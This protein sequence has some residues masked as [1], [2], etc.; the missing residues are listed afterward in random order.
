MSFVDGLHPTERC[1]G[2]YGDALRAFVRSYWQSELARCDGSVTRAARENGVHRSRLHVILNK[3][4]LRSMH[5]R[6]NR[7]KWGD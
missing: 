6:A 4:G 3:V 2:R 1:K 5:N 7:G